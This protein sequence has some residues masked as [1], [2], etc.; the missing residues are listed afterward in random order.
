MKKWQVY[1][2][3]ASGAGW[4]AIA[5]TA[6]GTEVGVISGLVGILCLGMGAIWNEFVD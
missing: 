1:A 2:W 5:L 4:W 6:G 3:V